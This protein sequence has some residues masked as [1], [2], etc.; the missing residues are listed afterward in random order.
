MAGSDANFLA[1]PPGPGEYT[2][3]YGGTGAAGIERLGR[4]GI[5]GGSLANLNGEPA[6][7]RSRGFVLRPIFLD[8]TSLI[9]EREMY[10]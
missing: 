3:H 10:S 6:M 4:G 9:Y 7:T 1:L 2:A 8:R 5:H